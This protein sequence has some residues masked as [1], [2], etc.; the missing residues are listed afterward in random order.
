MN[1]LSIEAIRRCRQRL[2]INIVRKT[3][4]IRSWNIQEYLVHMKCKLILDS[5]RTVIPPEFSA[6]ELFIPGHNI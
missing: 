4:K 3:L 6:N 2:R 5:I 1:F